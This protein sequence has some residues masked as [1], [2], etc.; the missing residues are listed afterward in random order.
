MRGLPRLPAMG[1][2]RWH[3]QSAN[4]VRKVTPEGIITTV[5]GTGSEGISADGGPATAAS[6]NVPTGVAVDGSGNIYV[7]V[8]GRIRRVD[9]AGIITTLGRSAGRVVDPRGLRVDRS[10]TLWV[11][12]AG[13][14][15]AGRTD[16]SHP[17]TGDT[18]QC[19]DGRSH[20]S[21]RGHLRRRQ[22][23]DTIRDRP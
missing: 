10:G 1:V 4:Q 23:A 15:R 14:H 22:S 6:L 13:A 21:D 16:F 12:D 18:H 19:T 3:D 20:G 7:T 8:G 2:R 9:R 11:A 17:S 5:A